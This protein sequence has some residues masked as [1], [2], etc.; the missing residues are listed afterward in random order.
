MRA[1]CELDDV[2]SRNPYSQAVKQDA[3]E[4]EFDW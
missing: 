2:L 4:D 1:I 3:A